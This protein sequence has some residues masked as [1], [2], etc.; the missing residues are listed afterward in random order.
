MCQYRCDVDHRDRDYISG[1][2]DQRCSDVVDVPASL[3]PY[4]HDS[5]IDN[6]YQCSRQNATECG[7]EYELEEVIRLPK[8]Q[9]YDDPA[10]D[11]HED[12]HDECERHCGFDVGPQDATFLE[13][14]VERTEV[15]GGSETTAHGT[16]YVSAHTDGSVDEDD[17]TRYHHEVVLHGDHEES[18]EEVSGSCYDKCQESHDESRLITDEE[19]VGSLD[20]VL[21]QKITS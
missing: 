12:G 17:H 13:V 6:E 14:H 1:G 11:C 10:N 16:E 8:H 21:S 18:G 20:F 2:C 4:I 19:S 7:D 5:Q 3:G 9:S 15:H